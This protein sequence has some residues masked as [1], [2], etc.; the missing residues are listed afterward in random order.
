MFRIPILFATLLMAAFPLRAEPGQEVLRLG[1]ALGMPAIIEIMRVEGINYSAELGESMFPERAG[2]EWQNL[3]EEIYD[4]DQ[5]AQATYQGFT[6]NLNPQYIGVLTDFFESPLGVEII[7]LEISARRALLDSAVEDAN[8]DHVA[9]LMDADD[10]RIDLLTRFIEVNNLLEANVV[11]G[12][13]SNF[14]F[15]TALAEGG[16]YPGE[17]TEDQLL[18]DVWSQEDEIREDTRI[19]LYEFLSMAYSPLSDEK[20][21]E[22]LAFSQTPEGQALNIALFA[23][24][25]GMFD[26]I[27][28]GLGVAAAQIMTSEDL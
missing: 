27:S 13:N 2:G 4:T 17:Q 14:A 1:D 24:F 25:D 6:A 20:L 22:Y 16:A 28:R 5:M 15:F 19:W 10:P 12:L 11:G 7:A 9:T 8:S 21:E 18:R 26:G 3:V 23:G